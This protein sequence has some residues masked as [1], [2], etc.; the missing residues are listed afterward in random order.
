MALKA[1]DTPAAEKPTSK[2]KKFKPPPEWEDKDELQLLGA[3]LRVMVDDAKSDSTI[4]SKFHRYKTAQNVYD[5]VEIASQIDLGKDY[6]PYQIQLTKRQVNGAARIVASQFNG[7]DPFYIF[8]GGDDAKLREAREK[9]TQLLLDGCNYKNKV[10]DAARIAAIWGRGTFRATFKLESKNEGWVTPQTIKDS[11]L[12]FAGIARE[13]VLP[14]D[15]ILYPI[16]QQNIVDVRMVGHRLDRPMYEVWQMQDDGDYFSKDDIEIAAYNDQNTPTTDVDNYSLDL[17][18]LLVK[19]YPG[20]DKTK[21]MK[22]YRVVWAYSQQVVIAISDYTRPTP[23]YFAPGFY[24][25]PNAF[26]P[27]H[28]LASSI[29]QLQCIL[30]D[31]MSIRIWSGAAAVRPNALIV[32]YRPEQGQTTAIPAIGEIMTTSDANAKVIPLPPSPQAPGDLANIAN[33]TISFAEAQTGFSTNA[34]GGIDPHKITAT[35]SAQIASG[36]SEEGEEKRTNFMEE[37]LRF[38]RSIQQLVSIPENF[39]ALKKYYGDRW[40][41]TS[42][43]DWEAIFEIAPNGQGLNNNPQATIQKIETLI[44]SLGSLG[45]PKLE[46]VRSGMVPNTGLAFDPQAAAQLITANLDFPFSTDKLLV[47]TT[48]EPTPPPQPPAPGPGDL[49]APPDQLHP[50]L[51]HALLAGSQGAPPGMDAGAQG[52]MQGLT[53]EIMQLLLGI[54]AGG[55]PQG[56]M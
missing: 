31:T 23:E 42:A 52:G 22:A 3:R 43:K 53:P 11:D 44:Q 5:D 14:Q 34:A 10:R 47:D 21:R 56:P 6:P 15:F 12:V 19:L 18:H 38:V 55:A 1:L 39:A 40:Q 45:I 7:A 26:W 46:D 16:S 13:S 51:L 33:E 41:T 49:G 2:T 8:K 50:E 36:V 25:D 28:S 54:G 29:D 24:Y 9:D 17:Y 20:N 4:L 35:Q 37:E 32:G 48:N 27:M 30:N